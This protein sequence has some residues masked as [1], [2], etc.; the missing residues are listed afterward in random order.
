MKVSVDL[1]VVVPVFNEA[2]NAARLALEI[3]EVMRASTESFEVLFVND[4]STDMTKPELQ[5][6]Q[7][8]QPWLRIIDLDGNF[9]EAAALCAG[10]ASAS[11]ELVATLDGDGQNDPHDL[12]RLLQVLRNQGCRVVS[13]WR[14]ERQEAFWLRVMPSRAANYL[15]RLV[16]RIP[17]HDTGCG[18][19]VYRREVVAGVQLPAGFHRFLPAILGV[20]AAEVAEAPVRDR[21]RQFGRS[22]YGVGRTLVVARDL[23]AVAL[24]LAAP[25]YAYSCAV[26]VTAGA[27]MACL[28]AWTQQQTGLAL[29]LGAV[30]LLS[31]SVWWNTRRFRCARL[32]GVY[33]IREVR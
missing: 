32:H 30:S 7:P 10:F 17:V 13:G 22:H 2:G 27:M 23:L 25:R 29:G 19:K 16:T 5:A 21:R 1:S 15:I 31:A 6:L 3:G 14:R 24:L 9:G 26:A 11:G 20:S 33:R 18:L 8:G 4:G 28:L 12:P